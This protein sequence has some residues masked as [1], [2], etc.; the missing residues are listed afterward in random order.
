MSISHEFIIDGNVGGYYD[1]NG[2]F[3]VCEEYGLT[4]ADLDR[5]AVEIQNGD[6]Y[7]NSDGWFVRYR[8]DD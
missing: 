2:H 5:Y 1:D 6:G 3:V 4:D 8:D 7:Y